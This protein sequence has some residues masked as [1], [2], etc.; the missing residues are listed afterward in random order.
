MVN[1]LKRG[2]LV[3]WGKNDTLLLIT[4]FLLFQYS[5]RIFY[6]STRA[7][8][9]NVLQINQVLTLLFARTKFLSKS[10]QRPEN[11]RMNIKTIKNG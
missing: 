11:K 8:D 1:E 3:F 6:D 7:V 9:L 4:K 10:Q 2:L 5:K